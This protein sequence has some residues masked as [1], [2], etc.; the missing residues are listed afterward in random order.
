MVMCPVKRIAL[1]G[2]A[3][4]ALSGC[5]S[6]QPT[7][8]ACVVARE[9]GFVG[10]EK[11]QERITVAQN[12]NPCTIAARI[13]HGSMGE[14]EVVAQPAHG[15]AAVRTTEEAT[16]IVYTPARDYVGADSFDVAFGPSFT[17]TV[18]VQVA[19]PASR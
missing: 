8:S 4:T 5:V 12:G 15:I 14:G 3:L 6:Q 13:R 16:E 1:I 2:V 9:S 7:Q 10:A 18:L 11:G 17:M 19:P